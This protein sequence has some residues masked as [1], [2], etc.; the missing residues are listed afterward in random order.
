M[1]HRPSS[2]QQICATTNMSTSSAERKSPTF[3]EKTYAPRREDVGLAKSTPGTRPE[4]LGAHLRMDL[5]PPLIALILRLKTNPSTSIPGAP[6]SLSR[7]AEIKRPIPSKGPIANGDDRAPRV[8]GA[9]LRTSRPIRH[10]RAHRAGVVSRGCSSTQQ[11][12]SAGGPPSFARTSSSTSTRSPKRV[13]HGPSHRCDARAGATPG[14]ACM[15]SRSLWGW[16][17]SPR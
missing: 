1:K 13:C 12:V 8:T 11:A 14:S 2:K 10:F 3:S 4:K 9:A 5:A 17:C 15:R 16:S 7:M 6:P